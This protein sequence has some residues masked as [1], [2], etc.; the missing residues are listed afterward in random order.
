MTLFRIDVSRETGAVMV[1][2][3]APCGFKPII[4]WAHLEGVKEF[5]EML[6]DF[7][8]SRKEERDE[9]ERVSDNLL[10]QALGGEDINKEEEQE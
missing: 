7:Y 4:G 5:A 9:V 3:E 10:R 6:L 8:N 2:M 1:R